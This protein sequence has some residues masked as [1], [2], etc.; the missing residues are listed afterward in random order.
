[1][2]VNCIIQ[3][4]SRR[5]LWYI[6]THI[7]VIWLEDVMTR[8]GSSFIWSGFEPLDTFILFYHIIHMINL[9]CKLYK[10][11]LFM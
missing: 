7:Y 11:M 2:T 5:W 3:K 4:T 10:S 8:I 9:F 1:M 6:F